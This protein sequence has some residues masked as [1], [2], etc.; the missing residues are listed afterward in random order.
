VEAPAEG[1]SLVEQGVR[2]ALAG[3]AVVVGLTIEVVRVV[4][5]KR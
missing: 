3:A 2:I 4:L 5:R 1:G